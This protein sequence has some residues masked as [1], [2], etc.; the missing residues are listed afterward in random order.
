[1]GFR[2]CWGLINT[3]AYLYTPFHTHTYTQQINMLL[4][5]WNFL[6]KTPFTEMT[7][8]PL[9]FN[10]FAIS[11]KDSESL[12][13]YLRLGYPQLVPYYCDLLSNLHPKW[14]DFRRTHKVNG[15]LPSV[16]GKVIAPCL[17]NP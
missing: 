4:Q 17:Q 2:P 10:K 15:T 1:M 6:L 8:K 5:I 11:L 14:G 16:S 12:D 9:F 3:H 13:T 7:L